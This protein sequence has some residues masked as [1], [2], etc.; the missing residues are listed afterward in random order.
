MQS[1]VALA[2]QAQGG[3]LLGHL[4][5]LDDRPMEKPQAITAALDCFLARCRAELLRARQVV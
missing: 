5:V 3:N 2:I 4:G 1:Y